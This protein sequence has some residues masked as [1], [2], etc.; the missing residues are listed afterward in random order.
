VNDIPVLSELAARF[1]AAVAGR[2]PVPQPAGTPHRRRLV[3]AVAA[4]VLAVSAFAVGS[5]NRPERAVAGVPLSLVDGE[6]AVS[7]QQVLDNPGDVE[8]Q[9]AAA[10]LE[11]T[12]EEVPASPGMVGKVRWS[13]GASPVGDESIDRWPDPWIVPSCGDP[14]VCEPWWPHGGTPGAEPE[15]YEAGLLVP[16]DFDGSTEIHIGRP[17]HTDEEYLL[18]Q[19][20]SGPGEPLFCR[21]V[22]METVT[23]ARAALADTDVPVV[24]RARPEFLPEDV[25]AQVDADG[26]EVVDDLEAVGDLLVADASYAD[27]QAVHLWVADDQ[28]AQAPDLQANARRIHDASAGC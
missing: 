21:V 4:V 24:W 15:G 17:A 22:L 14:R 2:A 9:L 7:Y 27:D 16:L 18:D 1:D 23:E 10:G 28:H 8:S 5:Y 26:D 11:V 6:L 19:H 20:P 3:L 13:M 12:I 25:L